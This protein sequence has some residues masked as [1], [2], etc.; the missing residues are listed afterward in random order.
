MTV[1][2]REHVQHQ[3]EVLPLQVAIGKAGPD[4]VEQR[5]DVPPLH[6]D[7][8]DDHLREHI[9]RTQHGP[10]GLDVV[11]QHSTR[12]DRRV[13]DV[14]RMR[15]KEGTAAHLT[16]LVAGSPHPLDGSRHGIGGLDQE[17]LVQIPDV[18]PHLERV[19][20]HNRLEVAGLHPPLDLLPDLARK[21]AVVCV[22][23]GPVH[24]LVD[25]LGQ[26]LGQTPV[27]RKDQRRP[28]LADPIGEVIH[29]GIPHRALFGHVVRVLREPD[30]QVIRLHGV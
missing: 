2:P 4:L 13:Q 28:I 11:G 24:G 10:D 25:L 16:H 29:E 12:E 18:D 9:Q 21:G 22:R 20:C 1:P 26:R 8:R 23:H 17:H 3:V 5:I 27:V 19:R 6:A 14:V 15:G 7:H 30:R